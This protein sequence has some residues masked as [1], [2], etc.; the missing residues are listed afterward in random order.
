VKDMQIKIEKEKIAQ[1]VSSNILWYL[2]PYISN[3]V[4]EYKNEKANTSDEWKKERG[5]LFQTFVDL[6]KNDEILFGNESE[7]YNDDDRKTIDTIVIHH[8]QTSSETNY[9]FLNGMGLV[10][11]Y[12]PVF[13]SKN[14]YK[15]GEPISSGHFYKEKK[16]FVAYHYLVWPNGNFIQV[17][18][19]NYVGFHAGHYDT[20]CKS[21][22][23]AFVDNLMERNPSDKSIKTANSIIAKYPD[24]KII[25]HKDVIINS[26]T[27]EKIKRTCPGNKWEEWKPLIVKTKLNL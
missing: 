21:I 10:R 11:L 14:F 12:A 8:T 6:L 27:G 18:K 4:Q 26:D 24:A 17:L 23:I 7:F 5:K 2:N 3:I 20:N 9:D 16:T 19:D 13:M 22:G 25:G 1:I 15:H